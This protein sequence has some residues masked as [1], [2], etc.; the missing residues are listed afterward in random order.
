MNEEAARV[1][2]RGMPPGGLRRKIAIVTGASRRQGIG[3]MLCRVLAASG[4]DVLFTHWQPFDREQSY[5][6]DEEGPGVLL[7]ELQE[8][9][10]RAV[11][12]N[13]DLSTPVAPS[14]V[15][16]TT[17]RQIGAPSILINNAAHW[18]PAGLDDLDAAVL[19]A[20]YYVNVRAMALL[21]AE[22]ARR[23]T[24]GSGG[25][26]VNLTS[27]QRIGA[28]PD[29]LAYAATKGAVEAFTLS[30]AAAVAD[31][32]ITV[33]AVDPGATDTGWMTEDVKSR[34][35]EQML[36]GRV[37]QP[38]DVARLILFLASDAGGWITGQVLHSRGM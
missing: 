29:Q 38:L 7:R 8:A 31:R 36:M 34:L 2:Y 20:H 18:S 21:S 15:L 16:E 1:L 11:A 17:H 9:G 37:G 25:R 24:G 14:L 19:D 10:V 28:M 30:F 35:A 4:V 6:A 26:I 33:N 32:G 5:G 22:F 3:A 23:F 12:L 27:G 13:V